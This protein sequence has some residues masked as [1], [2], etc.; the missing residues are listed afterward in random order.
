MNI[1]K[2]IFLKE[3]LLIDSGKGRDGVIRV[4]KKDRLFRISKKPVLPDVV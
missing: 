2:K 3:G 1:F 4:V